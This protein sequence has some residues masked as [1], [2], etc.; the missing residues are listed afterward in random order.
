MI[1]GQ[2]HAFLLGLEIEVPAFLLVS[3][4]LLFCCE[5]VHVLEIIWLSQ[6]PFIV[7]P[8]LPIIFLGKSLQL[9][10]LVRPFLIPLSMCFDTASY[11]ALC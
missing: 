7:L 5:L 10:F 1:W 3:Y 4:E 2:M 11:N 6:D 9:L 8:F